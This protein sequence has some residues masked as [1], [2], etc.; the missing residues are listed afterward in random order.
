MVESLPC[1]FILQQTVI[2]DSNESLDKKAT[3]RASHFIPSLSSVRSA[4]VL[5]SATKAA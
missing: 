1:F 5:Y 2:K 3:F 4:V